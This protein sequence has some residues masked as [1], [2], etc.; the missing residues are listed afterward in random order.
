MDDFL[1]LALAL[2]LLGAQVLELHNEVVVFVEEIDVL[3]QLT[4]ELQVL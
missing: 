1:G 4:E 3:E 2:L